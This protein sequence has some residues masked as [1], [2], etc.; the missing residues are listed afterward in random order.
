MRTWRWCLPSWSWR[1]ELF[2]HS[3]A[4]RLCSLVSCPTCGGLIHRRMTRKMMRQS[5]ASCTWGM[6]A[7]T[8][9]TASSP[10]RLSLLRECRP[11][12]RADV[13]GAVN[14]SDPCCCAVP[15]V[16]CVITDSCCL[17]LGDWCVPLSPPPL[18]SRPAITGQMP[19]VPTA[20]QHA[21]LCYLKSF[22]WLQVHIS[23]FL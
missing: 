14:R 9:C 2:R 13:I 4:H 11:T 17:P 7:Q 16:G 3:T 20:Y 8:A 15:Y 22:S 21:A 12:F 10:V 23:L 18:P 5:R 19:C 1:P 6:P